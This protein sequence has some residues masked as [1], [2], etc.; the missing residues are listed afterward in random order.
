MNAYVTEAGEADFRTAVLDR[1]TQVP[2]VVDFWA[3]WC[4]PCKSLGPLLERTAAEYEGAFELVKIDVDANQTLAGQMG[5]QSIPT[6]IAFV[7]GRPVSQFQGAIPDAQLREWLAAFLTPPTDPEVADALA[8]LDQGDEAAAEAKL[9]AILV[10]R[11]DEEASM[12]LALLFIDQDRLPEALELLANLPASEDV[13]RL[14]AITKMAQAAQGAGDLESQLAADPDNV[15]L[16]IKLARAIA[17][18]G[19]YEEALETL[20]GIVSDKIDESEAARNAM[21][22]IFDALGSDQPITQTYRRRLANALF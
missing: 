12:A 21:I 15:A 9:R 17:G 22:E 4:Q 19:R 11:F 10:D 5:I 2:V 3:E 20:V 16:Q 1:S 6:V 14:V 8:L 13:D 7:D 18:Q